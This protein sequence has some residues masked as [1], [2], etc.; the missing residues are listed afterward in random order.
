MSTRALFKDPPGGG[1]SHFQK[2]SQSL[3]KNQSVTQTPPRGGGSVRGVRRPVTF[4][5]AKKSSAPSAPVGGYMYIFVQKWHFY[6][7]GHKTM[8]TRLKNN[9]V[10]GHFSWGKVCKIHI[11][12]IPKHGF[13]WSFG[14]LRRPLFIFAGPYPRGG[15]SRGQ[16]QSVTF[17]KPVSHP[18][19]G[20]VCPGLNYALVWIQMPFL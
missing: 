19:G 20:R 5:R 12:T 3:L 15:G 11:F 7:C 13:C 6:T 8:V 10:L 9:L 18:P 4:Y 1:L 2:T 17:K 16:N 14:R